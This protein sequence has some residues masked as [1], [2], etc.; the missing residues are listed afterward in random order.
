MFQLILI[1]LRYRYGA[2]KP[3]KI[4]GVQVIAAQPTE[5]DRARGDSASERA[6][7]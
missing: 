1:H 2:P 3:P 6:I 4:T 5:A 7:E